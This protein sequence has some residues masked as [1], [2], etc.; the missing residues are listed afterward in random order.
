MYYDKKYQVNLPER[1]DKKYLNIENFG[2]YEFTY[3]IA[4][5]MAIRTEKYE[6]LI[7]VK[8]EERNREWVKKM[9]S[10]GIR[11]LKK[12][13]LS[14]SNM[15]LLEKEELQY[16]F[17]P[18]NWD[19]YSIY[20][21]SSGLNKVFSFYCNNKR[22]YRKIEKDKNDFI[23]VDEREF[24]LALL[25]PVNY[26]INSV[27]D[28]KEEMIPLSLDLP[29]SRLDDDFLLSLQL[30]DLKLQYIETEP[31]YSRPTLRFEDDRII[32][33]PINLN[34]SGEELSSYVLKAKEDYKIDKTITKTFIEDLLDIIVEDSMEAKGNK[35]IPKGKLKKKSIADAFFV[36]DLFKVLIP[37]YKNVKE[38]GDYML[39]KTLDQLENDLSYRTDIGTSYIKAYRT[40]MNSCIDDELYIDLIKINHDSKYRLQALSEDIKNFKKRVIDRREK[41]KK[42]VKRLT[43]NEIKKI[44][45]MHK[46]DIEQRKIARSLNIALS[47]VQHHLNKLK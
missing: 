25:S 5:E 35:K 2:D 36:Y 19:A 14:Y 32:N 33:L 15:E 26:Y 31:L 7:S 23:L 24:S 20:D 46:E 44:T 16:E 1:S 38:H 40:F 41:A 39:P 12:S 13:H 10:L 18:K 3:C 17:S 4:Y 45:S 11:D 27:I 29:L 42:T 47:T 30:S 28:N 37:I 8:E 34:L 9:H 6:S 21:I 22:L 43:E